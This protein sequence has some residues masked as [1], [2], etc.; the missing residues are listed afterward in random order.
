M[1][2][3][4]PATRSDPPPGEDPGELP[5]RIEGAHGDR[6]AAPAATPAA[7]ATPPNVGVTRSCQ[8]SPVGTATS[9]GATAGERS[10]AHR[11]S[12]ATGNAAIVTAAPTLRKGSRPTRRGHVFVPGA[13]PLATAVPTIAAVHVYGDLL[14][15]REL[16]GSLFRRDLRAKYKGSVL[17]LAWT[18]ALPA[19]AHAP[20]LPRC[21]LGALEGGGDRPST[22]T[23]CSCSAGCRR[24]PSSPSAPRRAHAASSRTRR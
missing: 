23:G 15:Y 9:R 19:R 14:R 12:D 24:G 5:G 2:S 22:T 4:T 11:T 7:M 8:R 6:E 17:G 1:S 18:L 10:R 16:F 20:R 13:G 3:I 21:L